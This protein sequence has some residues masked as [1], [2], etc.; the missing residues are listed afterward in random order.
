MIDYA[1]A[2]GPV[3]AWDSTLWL[4]HLTG[5]TVPTDVT[6]LSK[7]L[8]IDMATQFSKTRTFHTTD[9]EISKVQIKV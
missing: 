1:L 4:M 9:N 3:F 2:Y 8:D 5:T 7:S 6:L